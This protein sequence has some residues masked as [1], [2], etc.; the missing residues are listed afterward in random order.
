MYDTRQIYSVGISSNLSLCRRMYISLKNEDAKRGTKAILSNPL[1]HELGA[2]PKTG[3]V[4]VLR[5]GKDRLWKGAGKLGV[6][7]R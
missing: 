6:T 1:C 2:T 5:E 4:A 7:R 3:G